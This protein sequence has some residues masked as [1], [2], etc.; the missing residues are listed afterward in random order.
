MNGDGVVD[1]DD[2]ALMKLGF[3]TPPGPSG[4]AP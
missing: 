3:F 4:L 1:L 2:V